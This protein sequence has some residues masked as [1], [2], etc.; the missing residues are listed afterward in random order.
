MDVLF[1]TSE[2]RF[3]NMIDSSKSH[4]SVSLHINLM[5][6]V[7]TNFFTIF[8][9]CF[10]WKL[11]KWSLSLWSALW[12]VTFITCGKSPCHWATTGRNSPEWSC[13]NI[14]C[15]PKYHITMEKEVPWNRRCKRQAKE[16][17]SQYNNSWI[18][19]SAWWHCVTDGCRYICLVALRNRQM[20]SRIIHTRLAGRHGRRY[21]DQTIHNRLQASHLRARKPAKK[22]ALTALHRSARLRWCRQHR[23]WN[24]RGGEWCSQMNPGFVYVKWMGEFE[25]VREYPQHRG[26]QRMQWPSCS[27]DLSPIEHLWDLLGRAVRNR[28]NNATAVQDLWQIVVD[29][30]DAAQQRVQRLI[31]SMRR[32]CQAIT[33]VFGGSSHY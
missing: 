2:L 11:S 15:W 32:R 30:W 27:P 20:S 22:P 8:R 13:A 19:A 1:Y 14:W 7:L 10:R 12:H 25:I 29:E 24:P 5:Y 33:A 16:W 6:T 9:L 17:S 23:P 26:I 18:V 28:V 21:S 4:V 31:S 3:N